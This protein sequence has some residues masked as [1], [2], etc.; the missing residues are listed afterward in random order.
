[1]RIHIFLMLAGLILSMISCE[2]FR[3]QT[4]ITTFK[5]S[6]AYFY[7]LFY[8]ILH[9]LNFHIVEVEEALIILV[10]LFCLGYLV[11]Y[12]IYPKVIFSGAEQEYTN[13]VRIRLYGQGQ[14]S[15]GYFFA[16]NR[17]LLKGKS[18]YLA[19]VFL[20]FLVIFLMGFR[21][22]ILL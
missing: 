19:L 1:F 21:T 14:S 17:F 2:Y 20:C 9:Y 15:L 16:L 12:I 5:A 6:A 4:F 10:I 13:D 8:F 22:M 7:I 3:G 18:I 11:Q